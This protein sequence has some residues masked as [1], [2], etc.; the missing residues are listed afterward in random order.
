MRHNKSKIEAHLSISGIGQA[1]QDIQEKIE[2][3]KVVRAVNKKAGFVKRWAEKSNA[4]ISDAHA[5]KA[6]NCPAGVAA[7]KHQKNIH[8]RQIEV[9]KIIKFGNDA[10]V[11]KS[12]VQCFQDQV[13]IPV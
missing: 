2:R 6:G 1:K 5:I 12:I 4:L 10:R 3:A 11:W 9:R 7:W 8:S 13:L